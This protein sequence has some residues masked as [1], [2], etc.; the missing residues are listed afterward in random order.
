MKL[1]GIGIRIDKKDRGNP[2]YGDCPLNQSL[3]IVL[4]INY[5]RL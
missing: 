2:H 3:L 1:V 4:E 5:C